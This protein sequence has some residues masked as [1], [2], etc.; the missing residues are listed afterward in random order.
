VQCAQTVDE[1]VAVFYQS[2]LGTRPW[3]DALETL[4]KRFQARLV[5]LYGLAKSTMSVALSFEVGDVPAQSALDFIC[6]YH[7]IEPRAQFAMDQPVGTMVSCHRHF[8]DEFV[9]GNAFYQE[10]FIPNGLR[11]TSGMKVF[12]DQDH[13]VFCAVHRG[14][15]TSPLNDAEESLLAQLC[16]HLQQAMAL[17]M[18]EQHKLKP[19]LVGLAV[20][21]RMPQA[22]VLMD[23]TRHVV[24]HNQAA[25]ELLE[26]GGALHL[27]GGKL[28]AGSEREDA[29]LLL[30]L[31]SL[32]LSSVS[33]LGA[34]RHEDQAQAPG[35]GSASPDRRWVSLQGRGGTNHR[36]CLHALRAELRMGAFGPRNVALGILLDLGEAPHLPPDPYVVAAMWDLSP[37]ETKVAMRLREGD[38]PQ[39]IASALGLS[40]ATIRSQMQAVLRKTSTS[41]QSELVSVLHGLPPALV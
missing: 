33:C 31:R 38:T 22:M 28:S 8:S 24:F 4:R 15:G 35:G 14:V 11:Y 21:Q 20:L 5:N 40:L 34:P 30:V 3:G 18:R 17:Y 1:I 39:D 25:A 16:S 13:V 23:E 26:G 9:A 10:F 41:R 37:A 19:E 12:E 32:M 2:A 29:K 6:K 27:S 36:L 7:R